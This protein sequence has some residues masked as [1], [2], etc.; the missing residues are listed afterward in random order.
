M[1]PLSRQLLWILFEVLRNKP[2]GNSLT[3]TGD[4]EILAFVKMMKTHEPTRTPIAHRN[5]KKTK[6]VSLIWFRD[7]G[8]KSRNNYSPW[9]KDRASDDINKGEHWNKRKSETEKRKKIFK[10]RGSH[11]GNRTSLPPDHGVL[12]FP[13]FPNWKRC[14]VSSFTL[15]STSFSFPSPVPDLEL[16]LPGS[17]RF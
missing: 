14:Q 2:H 13:C 6:L 12:F 8:M 1:C 9:K 4:Y 3:A 15:H 10:A 7:R 11:S 5:T 16:Q 17:I